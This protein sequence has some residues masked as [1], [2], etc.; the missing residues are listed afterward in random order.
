[1]APQLAS[2]SKYVPRLCQTSIGVHNGLAVLDAWKHLATHADAGDNAA[3]KAWRDLR[4][5]DVVGD[6][7]SMPVG[8]LL[9]VLS[10]SEPYRHLLAQVAVGVADLLETTWLTSVVGNRPREDSGFDWLNFDDGFEK[11]FQVDRK[12]FSYVSSCSSCQSDWQFMTMA[13]DAGDAPG[14]KLQHSHMAFPNNIAFIAVPQAKG[15]QPKV[16]PLGGVQF[17][18]PTLVELTFPQQF[19]V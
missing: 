6:G 7:S 15:C 18:E 13:S 1:M 14:V 10:S 19:Y 17:Y 9:C 16:P 3:T 5:G 12:L 8:K 11:R 2:S 4:L